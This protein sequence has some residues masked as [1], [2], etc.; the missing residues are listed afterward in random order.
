MSATLVALAATVPGSFLA[1]AAYRGDRD[2]AA[3]DAD[4]KAKTVAVAVASAETRQ[5]AQLI[6]PG[7]HRIDLTFHHRSEPA[8]N[9]AGAA[10]Q[11]RLT[12]IV[13][14]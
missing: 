6:G 2:E 5:R 12:D 1:W 8:N 3:A 4:A 13:T 10:A 14:Y 9:A 7:A 11:G